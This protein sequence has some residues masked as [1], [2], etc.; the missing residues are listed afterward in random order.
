MGCGTIS[1]MC[2]DQPPLK[3]ESF[4]GFDFMT[5]YYEGGCNNHSVNPVAC[6]FQTQSALNLFTITNQAP[7]FQ[8]GIF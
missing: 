7:P 2:S 6:N 8:E 4:E 5:T 3:M 1:A